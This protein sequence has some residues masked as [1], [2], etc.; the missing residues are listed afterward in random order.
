[1]PEK[2]KTYAQQVQELKTEKIQLLGKIEDLEERIGDIPEMERTIANLEEQISLMSKQDSGNTSS[3]K[4]KLTDAQQA[5]E[6]EAGRAKAL[7]QQLQAANQR[8][9]ELESRIAELSQSEATIAKLE[10]K[11]EDYNQAMNAAN[12]ESLRMTQQV[13]DLRAEYEQYRSNTEKQVNQLQQANMQQKQYIQ[14]Q[15]TEYGDKLRAAEAQRDRVMVK[16]NELADNYRDLVEK[17]MR[18]N[19]AM[20]QA[21]DVVSQVRDALGGVRIDQSTEQETQRVQGSETDS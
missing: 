13:R 8:I 20:Q 12:R 11:A 5:A 2:P 17:V 21:P 9:A 3:S 4:A 7:N 16:Y 6:Q 1:M 19:R 10:Q 18:A 14:N 15:A